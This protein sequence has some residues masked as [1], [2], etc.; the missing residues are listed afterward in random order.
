MALRASRGCSRLLFE[1]Q[2][3]ESETDDSDNGEAERITAQIV[4][5]NALHNHD[6]VMSE[7]GP[8]SEEDEAA[9]LTRVAGGD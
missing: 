1:G 5:L 2:G 4:V 6:A 7:R 9:M 3:D 8:A